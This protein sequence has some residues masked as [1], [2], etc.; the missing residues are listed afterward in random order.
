L[1]LNPNGYKLSSFIGVALAIILFSNLLVYPVKIAFSSSQQTDLIQQKKEQI[2]LRAIL[3]NLGDPSRWNALIQP[4][5]QE[6]RNRHPNLDIQIAIDANN[7]YNNTRMKLINALSNQSGPSIDLVSVD[8]IWLGE[9]AKKGLVTNLTDRT[10]KWGHLSDWYQSNL[11]GSLYNKSI[12]GIWAWTDVRGIWYWKDLLNEAGINSSSLETW[13]GYIESAKKLNNALKNREIQGTILFDAALSPDL[14]Y[15]YL[16]MLGGNIIELKGGHPTKGAYW[17]P[18]YNGTE[19]V[20]A[21]EFIKEQANAGIKPENGDLKNLDEE[22]AQ[23]RFAIYLGGQWIPHW[24][25]PAEQKVSNFEKKIGFIPMFPVPNKGNQ[26]LTMMGGWVLSIPTVSE[27]KELAWELIT[28]MLE[29]RILAPWLAEYLY[30]PTQKSIGEG[31]Y[32]KLFEQTLPY[33]QQML[34]LIEFGRG[35]PTIPEYPSIAGDIRQAINEVQYGIKEPKQALD[36]AA[37][38]SAKTL[39]W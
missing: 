23:K 39:G 21:M 11:D 28:I 35:R 22:F 25:P 1:E 7:L 4:A 31:N 3:T 16:W 5:L 32:S 33:S 19:G 24:F 12:Y 38:K 10:Q 37:V 26:T 18:A 14:W 34:S 8:Q 29:P 36:D 20:R 13:Q 2:T 27:N 30:L 17:F 9:F 15:P 6:L